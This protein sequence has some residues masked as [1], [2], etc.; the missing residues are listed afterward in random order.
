M[1]RLVVASMFFFFMLVGLVHAQNLP[2]PDL[3][4]G[5]AALEPHIDELTMR[6]HHLKHHQA[7]T[8]KLNDALKEMSE[9]EYRNLTKLGVDK[10][11]TRL[12]EIPEK[13]RSAV[14]NHG[15]GY[16][17]HALFFKMMAPLASPLREDG[18]LATALIA[19]FQSV[20]GFISAFEK[21]AAGVFGSG[22]AWLYL[23][24]ITGTLHVVSTPNQDTPAMTSGHLP[25]LALDV[26]EHAY[27]LSYKNVRPDYIKAWWNVVNWFVSLFP[28]CGGSFLHAFI[29]LCCFFFSRSA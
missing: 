7:Y 23:N 11:L 5:Y 20:D 17:N 4:Y 9:N 10:L 21:V 3:E 6:T 8:N 18:A 2:L 15:G 13:W 19:N 25:L 29:Q 16:V 14:R 1:L 24:T 26:W 28:H 27:Y 22:W 12:N